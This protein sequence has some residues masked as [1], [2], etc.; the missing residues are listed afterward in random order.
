MNREQLAIAHGAFDVVTGVWPL[1]SMS[2]FEKLT[3]PKPE[4]W[5]VKTAGVLI[6]GVG[7]VLAMA[8]L[9]KRVT[10]EIVTLAVATSAGLA[11]ID[12]YYAGLR[13][14]ISPVYLVDAV[15]E[16][17]I[18]GAW[19]YAARQDRGAR[20]DAPGD[21]PADVVRGVW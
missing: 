17:G 13:R 5:L 20:G 12:V 19:T 14:R 18:I 10:P 2:S 7:S 21:A 8:G 1:V 3:G 6:A 4:A 9:R 16:L 15:I 11:A